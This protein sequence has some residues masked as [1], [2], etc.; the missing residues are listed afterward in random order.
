MAENPKNTISSFFD[1]TKRLKEVVNNIIDPI[2]SL[3]KIFKQGFTA[4]T[5]KMS[6]ATF[7]QGNMQKAQEIHQNLTQYSGETAYEVP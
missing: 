6:L 7:V 3:Q 1:Q 2:S 5:Q 4:D